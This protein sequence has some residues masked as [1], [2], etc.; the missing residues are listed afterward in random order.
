MAKRIAAVLI[1]LSG[2][3]HIDDAVIPGAIEALK[4]YVHLQSF[5]VQRPKSVS[6]KLCII[7]EVLL[8]RTYVTSF[9][10]QNRIN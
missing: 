3:I 9:I 2:T 1:D 7:D 5:L 6:Y 10:C 8:K 4:R